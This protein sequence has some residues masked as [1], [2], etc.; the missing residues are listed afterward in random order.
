MESAM[1]VGTQGSKAVQDS[2]KTISRYE[3]FFEDS[4]QKEKKGAATTNI[5]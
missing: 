1:S 2:V 5:D 3:T 4:A